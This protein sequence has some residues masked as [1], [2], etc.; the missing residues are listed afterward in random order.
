MQRNEPLAQHKRKRQM[1]FV[2]SMK[3]SNDAANERQ[4]VVT[5]LTVSSLLYP[6]RLGYI[7]RRT[8]SE[9]FSMKEVPF[10]V[11]VFQ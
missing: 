8:F 9:V 11:E 10:T 3:P 7:Y 6:S 4:K 1:P 5:F 2:S